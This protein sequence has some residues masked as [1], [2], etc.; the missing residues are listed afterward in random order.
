ML[1]QF[2]V[3]KVADRTKRV[4]KSH[5]AAEEHI[6]KSDTFYIISDWGNDTVVQVTQAFN[7]CTCDVMY[8][9]VWRCLG[10]FDIAVTSTRHMANQPQQKGV[11]SELEKKFLSLFKST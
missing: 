11:L 8:C 4:Q 1:V 5:K 10:H 3:K 9:I 6:I 2:Q 7:N